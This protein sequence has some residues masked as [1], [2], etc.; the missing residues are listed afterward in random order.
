MKSITSLLVFIGFLVLAKTQDYCARSLCNGLRHIGCGNSGGF[1]TYCSPDRRE[2]QMT[3]Q[4]IN[5]ILNRHNQ[6]RDVIASGR[7]RGYRSAPR[8]A[9]MMWDNELAMLAGMTARTCKFEHDQCRNTYR[10]QYSG[11][12]LAANW[13]GAPFTNSV[14]ETVLP[15]IDSWWA[16]HKDANMR[17]MQNY[18]QYPSAMFG[19]FTVM[20]VEYNNAVGCAVTT[21]KDRQMQNYNT[22][23]LVCNY[24]K[25]NMYGNRIYEEGRTASKCSSGTNPFFRALCSVSEQYL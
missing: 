23:L 5:S 25:S 10:F 3:P 17:V 24:G 4:F 18:P 12:N 22:L 14:L 21:Y 13:S 20:S 11:Q 2:I 9:T 7:L 19:H 8:M 15:M 16:E 6:N 1:S